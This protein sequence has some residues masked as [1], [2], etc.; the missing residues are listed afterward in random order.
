[1]DVDVTGFFDD[2]TTGGDQAVRGAAGIIADGVLGPLTWS[3]LVVTL[4]PGSDRDAV[5]AAQTLLNDNGAAVA[6]DGRFGPKT[7]PRSSTSS[8]RTSSTSTG[9][10]TTMCGST[11]SPSRP[12]DADLQEDNAIATEARRRGG[13]D[14]TADD[15]VGR[16]WG[17]VLD[18]VDVTGRAEVEA[19]VGSVDAKR[20]TELAGPSARF[21]TS[22]R[23][24][25]VHHLDPA[26]RRERRAAARPGRRA[27]ARSRRWRNGACRSEV[28]VEQPARA[29]QFALHGVRPRNEW[30]A[31]SSTR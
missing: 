17:P 26:T 21:L 24:R 6:V 25:R 2:D 31:G 1:M 9:S 11:S 20:L 23:P 18:D 14:G 7:A 12:S 27:R 28:H 3:E 19:V 15:G 16:R 4:Q 30:L 8:K 10:S 13:S 5:R 29:E 22:R